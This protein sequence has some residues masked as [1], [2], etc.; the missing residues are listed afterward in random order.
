[1]CYEPKFGA[2]V[3]WAFNIS[4]YHVLHE[5]LAIVV[6]LIAWQI[7]RL[8]FFIKSWRTY[9]PHEVP[10]FGNLEPFPFFFTHI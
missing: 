10:S 4:T 9:V 5:K 8:P 3:P 2:L 1:M 7:Q 6:I